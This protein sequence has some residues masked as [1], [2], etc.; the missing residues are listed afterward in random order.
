MSWRFWTALVIVALIGT[1]AT[2]FY[3]QNSLSLVDLSLNLGFSAWK[4]ATP[5]P[6]P[7]LLY[8]SFGVGLLLGGGVLGFAWRRAVA[9]ADDMER[10]LA[11]LGGTASDPWS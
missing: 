11:R 2:M 5:A 9:R 6:L 8:I 3:L 1:L 4:L 10:R 7:A